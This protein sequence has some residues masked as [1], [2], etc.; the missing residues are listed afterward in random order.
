MVKLID[1]ERSFE[2][3]IKFIKEAKSLDEAGA[4]MLRA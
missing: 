1:A 2:S 3:A 4:Q